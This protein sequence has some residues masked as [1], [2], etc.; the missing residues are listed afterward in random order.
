[1][2][3]DSGRQTVLPIWMASSN[4]GRVCTWQAPP[5]TGSLSPFLTHR[6]VGSWMA[7]LGLCTWH[8]A[9]PVVREANLLNESDWR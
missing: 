7:G 8:S 6:H 3:L 9:W 5:G 1:M 4:Q 2:I